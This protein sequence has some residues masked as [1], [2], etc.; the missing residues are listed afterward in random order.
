MSNGA[1]WGKKETH[2]TAEEA[3]YGDTWDHVALDPTSKLV[4]SLAVCERTQKQT[5][6]LVK[7][8]QSRPDSIGVACQ[9]S[10][11]MPMKSIPRRSWRLLVTVTRRHWSA[12]QAQA[13]VPSGSGLCPG[14]KAL[15]LSNIKALGQLNSGLVILP[16]PASVTHVLIS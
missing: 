14:E 4:V 5:M 11:L 13:E 3:E 6:A 12:S 7:D 1:M 2:C 9:R 16:E 15:P 8:A 10:S